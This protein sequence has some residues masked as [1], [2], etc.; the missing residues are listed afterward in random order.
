MEKIWKIYGKNTNTWSISAVV[1][2]LHDLW[3]PNCHP[4]LSGKAQTSGGATPWW[5]NAAGEGLKP[6]RWFNKTWMFNKC[7]II[8]CWINGININKSLWGLFNRISLDSTRS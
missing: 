8:K 3:V 4:C 7:W 1:S 6:Y 5:T 2:N